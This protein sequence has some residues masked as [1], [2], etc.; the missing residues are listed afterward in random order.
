MFVCHVIK[1][2]VECVADVHLPCHHAPLC[3][4]ITISQWICAVDF[5]CILPIGDEPAKE[6]V[7]P[8]SRCKNQLHFQQWQHC[9]RRMKK[10]T[11]LQLTGGNG[12]MRFTF[13]MRYITIHLLRFE[14]TNERNCIKVTILQHTSLTVPS[15]GS[16]RLY[17]TVSS[18]FRHVAGAMSNFL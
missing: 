12:I 5:P 9:K 16:S 11:N 14:P 3:C 7:T 4:P 8:S 6:G 2:R 13:S 17:E 1:Y 18:R 15:S 10:D